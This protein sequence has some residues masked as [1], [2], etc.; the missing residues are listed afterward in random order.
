MIE[1]STR[2]STTTHLLLLTAHYSLPT[3]SY[4][5]LTTC[6]LPTINS[7]KYQD[8]RIVDAHLYYYALF[9]SMAQM[10]AADKQGRFD[11]VFGPGSK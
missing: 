5:L 6:Y 11:P 3:T 9:R 1:S 10:A 7:G 8:D 4:S 2:T